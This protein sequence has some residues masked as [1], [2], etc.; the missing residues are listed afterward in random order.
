[1]EVEDKGKRTG[2][3]RQRDFAERQKAAGYKRTTV[4]IHEGEGWQF[5]PA[6]GHHQ[7]RMLKASTQKASSRATFRGY[8][9]RLRLAY[10]SLALTGNRSARQLH[11]PQGILNTHFR[12]PHPLPITHSAASD[13]REIA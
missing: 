9:M 5:E 13:S 1:M 2:A 3:D 10:R 12:E 4:W 7:F 8:F 6:L 11:Y